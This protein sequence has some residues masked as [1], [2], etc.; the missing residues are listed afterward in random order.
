MQLDKNNNGD[1]TLNFKEFSLKNGNEETIPGIKI[2][3]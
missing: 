3:F 1:D 2:N